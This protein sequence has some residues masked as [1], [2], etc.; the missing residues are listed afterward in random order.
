MHGLIYIYKQHPRSTTRFLLDF[1]VVQSYPMKN[2]WLI[3][4]MCMCVYVCV[5]VCGCVCMCV[6][7]CVCVRVRAWVHACVCGG[8]CVYMWV[9]YTVVV[10]ISLLFNEPIHHYIQYMYQ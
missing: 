9:T 4:I 3:I 10:A 2:N 5:C 8:V 1:D 6:W 7:M